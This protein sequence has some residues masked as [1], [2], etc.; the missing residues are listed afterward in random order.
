MGFATLAAAGKA[1]VLPLKHS[2]PKPRLGTVGPKSALEK[3]ATRRQNKV[4]CGQLTNSKPTVNATST[5]TETPGKLLN[6]PRLHFHCF[7]RQ[8]QATSRASVEKE[9]K[10]KKTSAM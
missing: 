4:P 9:K 6:Q 2:L 3:K 7:L 10:K 1:K 5:E 8:G